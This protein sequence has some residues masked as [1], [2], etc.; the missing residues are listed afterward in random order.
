MYELNFLLPSVWMGISEWDR[1]RPVPMLMIGDPGV[2]KTQSVYALGRATGLPITVVSPATHTPEDI[3]GYPYRMSLEPP[4]RV[5]ETIIRE[6]MGF[7]PPAWVLEHADGRGLFFLDEI[8]TSPAHQQALL[9]LVNEGLIGQIELPKLVIIAAANRLHH[10]ASGEALRAAF[11]NR[12]CIVEF[13]FNSTSWLEKRRDGYPP[14]VIPPAPGE[15][16]VRAKLKEWTALTGAFLS[17][18]PAWTLVA[19]ETEMIEP[20]PFPTP[21]SWDMGTRLLAYADAGNLPE[22]VRHLLLQGCVGAGAS[23]EFWLWKENLDLPNLDTILAHP[24]EFEPPTRLDKI[25]VVSVNLANRVAEK[26]ME[27]DPENR[28][29]LYETLWI[30]ADRIR[31]VVGAEMAI[32][33]VK[34]AIQLMKSH[35]FPVH[36]VLSNF[37]DY[38][39]GRE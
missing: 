20:T 39:R 29:K 37:A 8:N 5:G 34:E 21:R 38:V 35:H 26:M 4:I 9:K 18:H 23:N 13:P 12:F 10:A 33:L 7:A 1:D 16:S 14:P 3:G 36:P 19:P 2:G 25:L 11:V 28:K 24:T 27:E 17:V 15:A 31:T 22:E 32:P 30:L 6:V